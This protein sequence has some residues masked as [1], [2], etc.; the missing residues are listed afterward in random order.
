[1]PAN[2][3]VETDDPS[4]RCASASERRPGRRSARAGEQ[5]LGRDDRAPAG[6]GARKPVVVT[7]TQAIA[8]GYGLVDG[9]NCRLVA[10]GDEEGFERALA[11]RARRRWHGQRAGRRRRAT[12]ERDLSWERWGPDRGAPAGSR[13][14]TAAPLHA[15][16][17]PPGRGAAARRRC[18]R[19]PTDA[20]RRR[21][22][23]AVPRPA[24]LEHGRALLALDVDLRHDPRS[25]GGEPWPR[26]DVGE[27]LDGTRS[28]RPRTRRTRRE[29]GARGPR[30]AHHVQLGLARAA[31]TADTRTRQSASRARTRP[32]PPR[33]ARR[34]PAPAR[35]R[36]RSARRERART[37]RSSPCARRC[38]GRPLRGSP[39]R[40]SPRATKSSDSRSTA[41]VVGEEQHAPSRTRGVARPRPE[42]AAG[43][44][45]PGARVRVRSGTRSVRELA[46]EAA[47][48]GHRSSARGYFVVGRP[49]HGSAERRAGPARPRAPRAHGGRPRRLEERPGRP[50]ALPRARPPPAGGGHQFLRAL[51]ASSSAAGPRGRAGP[52][53]GRDERRAFFNSFNFD[54]APARR[55]AR[56]LQAGPPRRRP[57]RRLPRVR[58]RTPTQDRRRQ[59][60]ARRR[61]DLPVALQPREARELGYDL[62]DPS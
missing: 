56:R 6:D 4:R 40:M 15:R 43:I 1:M 47:R 48:R 41:V 49:P 27:R 51:S 39:S 34:S 50:R 36:R 18:A 46:E 19:T 17:S 28:R 33:A 53:L 31:P 16:V 54:F 52:H 35:T 42:P 58:R 60:G 26:R 44:G 5:L 22:R 57:D 12:V 3:A 24:G 61:D 32:R 29:D 37:R 8:T 14:T 2:V 13:S 25:A 38:R 55:F 62:R 10:P 9:E 23:Y 59:P 11:G 7:R 30:S 20:S 21:P 45:R